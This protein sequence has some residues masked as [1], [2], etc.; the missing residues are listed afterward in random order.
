[1]GVIL[2]LVASMAVRGAIVYIVLT[3]N[4]SLHELLFEKAQHAIVKQNAATI[5]D[6]LRNDLRYVGYSLSSGNA[7]LIADSNKVKFVGDTDNNGVVDT[8]YFYLGPVSE[9]SGT[10]NPSDRIIYRQKNGGT[11]FECGHGVTQLS[12]KYYNVNGSITAVLADI[13]SYSIKL[14]VQGDHEINRYYP[15]SIWE[16]YF[17]PSNI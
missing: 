4:I 6:I 13:R 12:L 10:P 2:D 9:M 14:V 3:M 16:T 5:A 1:M 11:P 15:T 7:F 8:I 17:I